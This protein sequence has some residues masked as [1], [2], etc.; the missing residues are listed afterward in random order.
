S[1]EHRDEEDA[2]EIA[3]PHG[4]GFEFFPGLLFEGSVSKGK[5]INGGGD[6]DRGCQTPPEQKFEAFLA[7]EEVKRREQAESKC[8]SD[9]LS[10]GRQKRD[11]HGFDL[12]QDHGRKEGGKKE[13]YREEPVYVNGGRAIPPATVPSLPAPT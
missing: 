11:G 1:R 13:A 10:E 6:E 8:R 9:D 4:D 12:R 7:D 5:R 3:H 2:D